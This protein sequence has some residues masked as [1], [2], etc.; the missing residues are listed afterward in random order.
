[1]A[2]GLGVGLVGYGAAARVFHAPFIVGEP[3]LKLSKVVERRAERSREQYP[4]VEVVRDAEDLLRDEAIK[5]VVVA[6]PNDSH[7]ELARRALLAGKHV[8]VEKPFTVTSEEAGQLIELARERGRIVCAHQNRRWD[9]DFLTVGKLLEGGLLGRLVEFES[10]FDRFRDE[11]RPGAWREAERP[12]SGI[13]YDLGSH[14]ID[15]ALVLFGPPRAL[16]ADVRIQRADDYFELLLH[17]EGLKVTLK[18]GM[19]VRQPTPRFVLRGTRGSYVKYGLDP[20]EEAL[21][22]GRVP[23]GPGWGGEPRER[24]GLLDADAAG[25]HLEARV[26][27]LAGRYQE[28]YRNVAAAVA[29]RAELAVRPEDARRTVRI[30]ELAFQSSAEK[31]TISF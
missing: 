15:Q 3:G 20:Q 9:G 10:R 5:L 8:V 6:T 1:M 14:L 25:L 16:T 7:F 26:E 4:W 28:F 19:L 21:K 24:W 23:G 12:G 13:L 2:E 27:T 30:I 29:G 11:P 22:S 18:A 31:R 17:Y